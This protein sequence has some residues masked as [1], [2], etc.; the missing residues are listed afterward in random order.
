MN[1]SGGEERPSLYAKKSVKQ[2]AGKQ[3]EK[4]QSVETS[5]KYA[6]THACKVHSVCASNRCEYN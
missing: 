6:K 4:F 3:L 5:E 1:I 2:Q